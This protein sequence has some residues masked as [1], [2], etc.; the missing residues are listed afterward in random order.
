MPATRQRPRRLQPL[1]QSHGCRRH[2]Q[3][4]QHQTSRKFERSFIAHIISFFH[5]AFY[6]PHQQPTNLA[7]A[8]GLSERIFL[9]IPSSQRAGFRCPQAA[10]LDQDFPV[11][12][13]VE[14]S[15]IRSPFV[16]VG[17]SEDNSQFSEPNLTAFVCLCGNASGECSTHIDPFKED[18]QNHHS[19]R[20]N[21]CTKESFFTFSVSVERCFQLPTSFVARRKPRCTSVSLDKPRQTTMFPGGGSLARSR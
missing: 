21:G 13:S 18:L 8:R 9:D 12:W 10:L 3:G 6:R 2:S 20:G 4:N 1:S 15:G 17:S 7:P 16:V 11:Q 19:V 5:E 14:D